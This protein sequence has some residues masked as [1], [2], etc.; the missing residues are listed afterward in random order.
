MTAGGTL[1]LV[2]TVEDGPG[3]R[4]AGADGDPDLVERL[5]A[6]RLDAARMRA[7]PAYVVAHDR[8]LAAIAEARPRSQADL[9]Q[10]RGVG[11]TVRGAP[12]RGRAG[13]RR[14]VG[15]RPRS[16]S[17]ASTVSRSCAAENGL[18]T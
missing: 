9:L 11:H 16:A 10:V 17:V 8:T 5:R 13:A 6:W 15:L 2:A 12:R 1:R 3:R 4:G 18:C 7:V 14:R